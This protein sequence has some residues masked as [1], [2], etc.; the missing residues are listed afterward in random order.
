MSLIF[1]PPSK[2]EKMVPFNVYEKK[3]KKLCMYR[4]VQYKYK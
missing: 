1:L 2:K 4:Y 3:K